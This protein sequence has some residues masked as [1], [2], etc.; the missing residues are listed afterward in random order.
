MKEE[1]RTKGGAMI[2]DIL[3]GVGGLEFFVHVI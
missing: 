2:I 3:K 1:A